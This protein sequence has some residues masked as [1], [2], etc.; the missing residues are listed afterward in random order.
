MTARFSARMMMN[1]RSTT[2]AAMLMVRKGSTAA[3]GSGYFLHR[4]MVSTQLHMITN[5]KCQY[6][7]H[8]SS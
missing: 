7:F 1:A 2:A 3:M 5:Q 4:P 8:T 6:S